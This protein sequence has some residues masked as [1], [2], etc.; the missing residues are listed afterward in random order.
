MNT[1]FWVD[2]FTSSRGQNPTYAAAN[3]LTMQVFEVN[4]LQQGLTQVFDFIYIDNL[5]FLF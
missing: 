3:C 5:F 4:H 2:K 1:P